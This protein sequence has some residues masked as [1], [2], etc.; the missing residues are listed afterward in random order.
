MQTHSQAHLSEKQVVLIV[1]DGAEFS[2]AVTSRWQSERVLPSFTLMGGE[3]CRELDPQ[4]FDVALVGPVRKNVLPGAL[5]ALE[6]TG[7]PVICVCAEEHVAHTVCNAQPG[8]VVLRQHEGWLDAV[9]QVTAETLRRC[10]ATQ[11]A[12]RA[13]ASLETLQRQATLGRYMLD[14]RHT[15]NNTLT[16][17]LGNAELLLLEP[18]SLSIPARSQVETIRNMALRMHEILQRFSSLEKELSVMDRQ[19]N[20]KEAGSTQAAAAASA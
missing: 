12:Q 15:L 11:R 6:Q 16:S 14:M 5:K 2:R 4:S 8:V 13:E 19:D 7:K 3:L 17:V 9:I 1:S 10:A 20:G 18:E